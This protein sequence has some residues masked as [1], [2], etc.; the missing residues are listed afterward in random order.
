MSHDLVDLS[1][2]HPV[3]SSGSFVRAASQRIAFAKL[4]RS[5]V[6]AGNSKRL[7]VK[8]P[9]RP[10]LERIAPQLVVRDVVMTAEYYRDILGF[11]ILG[12]FLDPPVYAMV[13]RDGIQLHFGQAD[14]PGVQLSNVPLRK[15]GFDLYIWTDDVE[16]LCQ[17]FR[18]RGVPI[19]RELTDRVYGNREFSIEDCN[20]F[21]LTFGQ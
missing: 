4:R 9:E 5:K 18:D 14:G 10:H 19:A 7:D 15:V 13:E 1:T 16:S 8:K 3:N 12:Y 6:A 11:R 2:C 20:G 17:E 21:M